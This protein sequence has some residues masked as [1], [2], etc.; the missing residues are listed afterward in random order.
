M[1]PGFSS[2]S[3]FTKFHTTYIQT[4]HPIGDETCCELQEYTGDVFF[5]GLSVIL[6]A[7][8]KGQGS[9]VG[10]SWCFVASCVF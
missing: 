6:S 10:S 3:S 9:K 4:S 7:F 1:A 2:F 8:F 5:G